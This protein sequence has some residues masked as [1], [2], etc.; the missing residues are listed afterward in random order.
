VAALSKVSDMRYLILGGAGFMGTR[1]ARALVEQDL[2]VR[3]FDRPNLIQ[4]SALA[5]MNK[6]E[7]FF[8]DFLNQENVA[9]AVS[10]CDVIYHLI[11]TT[12]PKSSNENPVYDVESN[13][14]STIRF[15]DIASK[16]HVK[17]VIFPSSGGTVYGIPR[18]TPID[19]DHPTYP[20]ASYGISKLTIEKYLNL[21]HT[22][23][24]LDYCVLRIGNP[25]GPG[26]RVDASQG[27]VGVFLNKA[28]RGKPIEVWGDGS[29]V[30]DYVY[31]D[32]VVKAFLMATSYSGPQRIFNIGSGQGLSIKQ[33]LDATQAVIKRPLVVNYKPARPYDVPINVLD[34]ARARAALAWEPTVDINRGL[35]ETALWMR[36]DA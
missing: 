24:G 17:K 35:A 10:G 7:W 9:Q 30:R 36:Q 11:S 12:L 19:E 22:L 1:L 13:I 18:Y 21:F 23:Y 33:L 31:I 8:G 3:V 20:I 16:Q 26:Q 29:V 27:A 15:L 6:I 2:R 28:L 4:P 14:V 32:D 5:G 25:Y 34:I